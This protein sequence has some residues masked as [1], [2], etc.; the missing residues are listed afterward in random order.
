M[1]PA[2]EIWRLLKENNAVLKRDK[3]HEVWQL[4]NGKTWVR[5]ST[6]SCSTAEQNALSDLRRCLGEVDPDRGK[7]G[8]RRERKVKHERPQNPW[9]L[10][11]SENTVLADQL[12][13]SGVVEKSLK[14]KIEELEWRVSD[15]KYELEWA[16]ET[17]DY[18]INEAAKAREE[19]DKPHC[20]W[21]CLKAWWRNQW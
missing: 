2:T 9:W 16:R 11:G 6:P 5:S 18:Y 12:R 10:K 8:E 3:K 13:T 17:R 19:A 4:P 1:N 21:C 20:W 7:P 15:L 14:E